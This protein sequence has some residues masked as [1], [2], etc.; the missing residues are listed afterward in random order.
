ME[1]TYGLEFKFLVSA[2]PL[3][4]AMRRAGL[5][6]QDNRRCDGGPMKKK[7]RYKPMATPVQ[8]KPKQNKPMATKITVVLGI[9]VPKGWLRSASA[10]TGGDL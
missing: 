3:S 6:Q 10:V 9:G 8:T 7:W 1:Q 5:Q 4:V 2:Y